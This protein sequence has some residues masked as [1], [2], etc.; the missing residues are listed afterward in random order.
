[1]LMPTLGLRAAPPGRG[2]S[3]VELMVGIAIGLFVVAAAAT[4][5]ATQL[6]ENRKVQLE[7]QVQ[8]DLRATADIITR[9]LR[10]SASLAGMA[11]SADKAWQP[12]TD[13]FPNYNS[14]AT[15]ASGASADIAFKQARSAGGSGSSGYKLVNGVVLTVL[16]GAAQDQPLTDPATMVVTAF[17]IQ[18]DTELPVVAACPKLCSDGTDAC[19]PRSSIRT[20]TLN[21]TG[22]SANDA[23]VV[24]S[25]SSSVRVRNDVVAGDGALGTRNCPA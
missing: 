8:Q 14:A 15:P 16:E 6:T 2:M 17:S 10:R 5:V 21:M 7:L 12:G 20:Y 4:L 18:L 13:W 25:L 24:R 3:L 11:E 23:S 1:M 22:R 9:E 19:W